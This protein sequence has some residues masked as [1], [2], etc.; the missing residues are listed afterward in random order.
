MGGAA[1]QT[2]TQRLSTTRSTFSSKRWPKELFMYVCVCAEGCV[3][4][5]GV[6]VCVC[7]CVCVYECVRNEFWFRTIIITLLPRF[8]ALE[9]EIDGML[10]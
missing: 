3:C 7:V 10:C 6:C 5:W 1:A 9:R 4:V 8:V 2:R